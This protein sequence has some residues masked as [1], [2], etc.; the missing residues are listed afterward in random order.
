MF[1]FRKEELAA[2]IIVMVLILL[3]SIGFIYV[4]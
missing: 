2:F 4:L 1:R 3:G